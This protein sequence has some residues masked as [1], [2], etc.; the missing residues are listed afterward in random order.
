MART[1]ISVGTS[2]WAERIN[3]A[4]RRS[5]ASFIDCGHLL[6]QAKEEIPRG[7]FA[8]MIEARLDFQ[9]RVAQRLMSIARDPRLANPTHAALLPPSW[10]VL[11]ELTKLDDAAFDEAVET[12]VINPQMQRK[13]VPRKP[14]EPTQQADSAPRARHP[15]PEPEPAEDDDLGHDDFPSE[16]FYDSATEPPRQAADHDP[17]VLDEPAE[18]GEARHFDENIET[19]LDRFEEAVDLPTPSAV[20]PVTSAHPASRP[21]R[22]GM[23]AVWIDPNDPWSKWR[24]ARSLMLAFEREF[25]AASVALED[26]DPMSQEDAHFHSE[27]AM[28]YEDSLPL[29]P[30]DAAQ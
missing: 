5:A 16:E 10:T 18:T 8:K 24:V 20:T 12:R 29:R 15:E 23:V 4:W 11:Y 26:L 3:A 7:D 27:W 30:Q 6:I 9:P 2:G 14:R 21:P 19:Q 17:G 28:K 22:E 1:S 25:D 13:D